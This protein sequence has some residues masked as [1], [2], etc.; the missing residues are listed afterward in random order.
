MRQRKIT[1]TRKGQGR[2]DGRGEVGNYLDKISPVYQL[3]Y[4]GD[5]LIGSV[6]VS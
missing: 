1:K 4:F 2:R 5:N 6:Q 3:T